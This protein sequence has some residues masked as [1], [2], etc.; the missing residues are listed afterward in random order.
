MEQ[1]CRLEEL[2]I[3][4]GPDLVD[5]RR[6]GVDEKDL[7]ALELTERVSLVDAGRIAPHAL[8]VGV[9]YPHSIPARLAAVFGSGNAQR[10][11]E[12]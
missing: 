3:R 12:S 7:D 11:I 6:L 1:L 4:T 8:E 10:R 5:D 2:A 9:G